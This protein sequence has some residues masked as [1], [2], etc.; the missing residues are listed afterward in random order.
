MTDKERLNLLR[1]FVYEL[2]RK[3]VDLGNICSTATDESNWDILFKK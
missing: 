3:Q 2:W 1:D